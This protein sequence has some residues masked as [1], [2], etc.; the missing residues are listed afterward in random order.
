[1]VTAHIKRQKFAYNNERLNSNIVFSLCSLE[2]DSAF[3]NSAILL[4]NGMIKLN[5]AANTSYLE[6]TL[7][8]LD[9]QSCNYYN[10]KTEKYFNWHKEFYVLSVP[11]V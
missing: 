3:G 2:R 10:N 1:M 5:H 7:N 6:E 8:Q 4:L 9:G 11:N